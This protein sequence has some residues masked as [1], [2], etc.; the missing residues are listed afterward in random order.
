M[1]NNTKTISSNTRTNEEKAQ[2]QFPTIQEYEPDEEK[3]QYF[4]NNTRTR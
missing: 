2:I 3:I 1:K 4:S